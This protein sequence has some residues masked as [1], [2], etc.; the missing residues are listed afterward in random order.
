[1]NAPGIAELSPHGG[2]FTGGSYPPVSAPSTLPPGKRPGPQLKV[3]DFKKLDI[4]KKDLCVSCGRKTNLSYIEKLT[5]RRRKLPA[6]EEPGYLCKECYLEMA[7][8]E[9][10]SAPPLP[11]LID[12][13]RLERVTA[14]IGRCTVCDLEKA[15]WRDKERGVALCE[16]CWGREVRGSSLQT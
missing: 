15:V 11:G 13:D 3:K 5:D 10:S 16:G 12:V 1:M 9:R 2:D 6:T 4:I 7:R 14:D 8:R